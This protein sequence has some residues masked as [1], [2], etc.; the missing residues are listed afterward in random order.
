MSDEQVVEN[1]NVSEQAQQEPEKTE[2]QT[3][4]ETPEQ[5]NWKK[6]RQERAEAEAR[7]KEAE[8]R[9][10]RKAEEAE[11]LKAALESVLNKPSAQQQQYE[12]Q[13]EE[14][15]EEKILEQKLERLLQA[16]DAKHREEQQKRELQELPQKLNQTFS[17]FGA[18]CNQENLDYMEFHHPEIAK[19]F[20]HMPDS[21]DKW[22]SVYKA[23]KKLV[24]TPNSKKDEKRIDQN[25]S[26]PQSMSIPGITQTGD[27]APVYLDAAK[28]QANWERMQRIARGV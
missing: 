27:S 18:V 16:R 25:L 2:V 15:N 22:A 4:E 23:V 5:I 26:K 9:A 6:F 17:D 14:E 8:E 28:K 19:A 24:P 13:F 7:R 12:M 11:A 21:F 1:T 10:A 3:Q 20:Q